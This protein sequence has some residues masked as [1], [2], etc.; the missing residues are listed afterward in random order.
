MVCQFIWAL[1]AVTLSIT[2]FAIASP[3]EVPLLLVPEPD[4]EPVDEPE[5]FEE[6]EP[7]DEPDD[8]DEPEPDVEPVD[9]PLPELEP[10]PEEL[11]VPPPDD[12]A[13]L[14]VK[15]PPLTLPKSF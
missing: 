9:E 15:L 10:L 7:D 1:V 6:P 8:F 11:V 3:D 4:V 13:A 14:T 5:D 12:V 2:R